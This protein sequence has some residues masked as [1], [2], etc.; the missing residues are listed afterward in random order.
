MATCMV[1]SVDGGVEEPPSMSH[2][3]LTRRA[4]SNIRSDL[5][6]YVADDVLYPKRRLSSITTPTS[7]AMCGGAKTSPRLR[8][9][10]VFGGCTELLG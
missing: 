3:W 7:L 2:L 8:Q 6:S 9:K 4:L 10:R 5:L 1:K